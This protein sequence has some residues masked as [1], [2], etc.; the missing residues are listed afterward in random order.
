MTAVVNLIFLG[1]IKKS[2]FFYLLWIYFDISESKA[3][4]IAEAFDFLNNEQIYYQFLIKE[5]YTKPLE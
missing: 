5:I 1:R 2:E 3:N 4:S